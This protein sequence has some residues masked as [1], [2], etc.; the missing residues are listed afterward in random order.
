[1]FQSQVPRSALAQ[2]APRGS[3]STRGRGAQASRSGFWRQG[4]DPLVKMMLQ[5]LDEIDH[6]MVIVGEGLRVLHCNHAA[7]VE[8]E[9]SHPLVIESGRLRVRA[10]ADLLPLQDALDAARGRSLRRLLTLR[11][12]D[13][14]GCASLSVIPLSMGSAAE[15]D[16]IC[17]LVLAKSEMCGNLAVQAFAREHK[18][19]PGELQVLVALCDGATP[20]E[21]A[22][23]HGVAMSTVRTQIASIRAKTCAP[24][25]RELVRQVAIL[26]P[27]VG[28][29]RN[30]QA[31]LKPSRAVSASIGIVPDMSGGGFLASL[32]RAGSAAATTAAQVADARGAAEG[33]L[34]APTT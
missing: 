26:P 2:P 6:G 27:L 19:S 31:D 7:R 9:A 22:A 33:N 1:M 32:L 17:L 3:A 12:E 30:G 16:G 23:A 34:D 18:L 28:T 13:G 10:Q 15:D 4:N 21:I 24:G 14:H 20:S 5:A 8:L 25:I 11:G 29:L